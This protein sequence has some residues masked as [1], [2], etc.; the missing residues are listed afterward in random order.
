MYNADLYTSAL[1]DAI[2]EPAQLI[3][4]LLAER[5]QLCEKLE[6][7][8]KEVAYHVCDIEYLVAQHVEILE[9]VVHD[10]SLPTLS[11]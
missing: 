2:L 10:A 5:T 6:A 9:E 4:Q 11:S 7:L 3:E 1:T 8:D